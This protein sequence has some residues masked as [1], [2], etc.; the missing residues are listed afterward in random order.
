MNCCRGESEA[1][2]CSLESGRAME[3]RMRRAK[4][5]WAPLCLTCMGIR[6]SCILENFRPLSIIISYRSC[7]AHDL[8][9]SRR[10]WRTSCYVRCAVSTLGWQWLCFP[11]RYLYEG[12]SRARISHSGKPFTSSPRPQPGRQPPAHIYT[13]ITKNKEAFVIFRN[14]LPRLAL[15]ED[16]PNLP[17]LPTHSI[18]HELRRYF[19]RPLHLFW[20][21]NGLPQSRPVSPSLESPKKNERR[22][23]LYD[24]GSTTG[25]SCTLFVSC[26][27]FF[28]LHTL[29]S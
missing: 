11:P 4:S 25:W 7:T 21:T 9:G 10:A 18:T 24:G 3:T 6:A 15:G 27:R 23:R 14:P 29:S 12:Q 2:L 22:K 28:K 20:T 1:V 8:R 5:G 16:G 26:F 13:E 17:V 19:L